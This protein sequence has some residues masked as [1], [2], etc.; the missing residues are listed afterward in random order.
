MPSMPKEHF[1]F[2]KKKESRAT[3]TQTKAALASIGKPQNRCDKEYI[4]TCAENP[5]QKHRQ[6]DGSEGASVIAC[7]SGATN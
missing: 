7:A 2:K 6:K 3:H 1:F 5:H 4:L